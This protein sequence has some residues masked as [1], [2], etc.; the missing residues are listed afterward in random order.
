MDV[1]AALNVQDFLKAGRPL[2]PW[3]LT[4]SDSGGSRQLA[5]AV[6]ASP[7]GALSAR[8]TDLSAQEDAVAL[9]W[10][11][12][13]SASIDG[14]AADMSRQ[15][16]NAFALWLD[17]RIDALGSSPI[18]LGVG[19]AKLDVTSLLRGLPAGQAATVKIPLRCFAD[20]AANL[21]AVSNA[22][23]IDGGPGLALTLKSARTGAVGEPLQCPP[24]A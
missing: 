2:A 12:D 6:A 17:L 5:A 3:V 21:A 14:P 23:R 22:V 10:T 1:T 16:N 19:G 18:I 4:L 8:P 7:S 11:G 20:A 9:R 24:R 13:G 15:L